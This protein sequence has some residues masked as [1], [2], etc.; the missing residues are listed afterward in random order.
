[1]SKVVPYLDIVLKNVCCNLRGH[2]V[3]NNQLAEGGEEIT[4][5]VKLLNLGVLVLIIC[6]I[7]IV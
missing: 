7:E 3:V 1:M 2:H 6:N 4:T 5:L